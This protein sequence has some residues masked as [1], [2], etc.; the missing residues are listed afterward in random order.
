MGPTAHEMPGALGRGR[1]AVRCTMTVCHKGV[2][3]DLA[4]L[5]KEAS[6]RS[7][8]AP[9]KPYI[10][11]GGNTRFKLH[12]AAIDGTEV[13]PSMWLTKCGVKFATWAFTSASDL[14][15]LAFRAG[16]GGRT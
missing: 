2:H 3:A 10:A 8:H 7:G 4:R 12:V 14:R 16:H 5:V 11:K 6:E 1:W 13:L 15:A 9:A